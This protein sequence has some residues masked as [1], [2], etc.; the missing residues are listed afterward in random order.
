MCDRARRRAQHLRRDLRLGLGRDADAA[1]RAG[2]RFRRLGRRLHGYG[3]CTVALTQNATV[4]AEFL[5][6]RL[7][8]VSL[9]RA[10]RTAGA[11]CRSC[12]GAVCGVGPGFPPFPC[13]GSFEARDAGG[14][15][16]LRGA[17]LGLRGLGRSLHGHGH[18]IVSMTQHQVVTAEF[19]GPRLLAVN[20]REHRE[21][22][23]SVQI[24]PSA[25]SAAWGRASRPSPATD[26]SSRDAG[27]AHAASRL[28]T[29]SSVGWGGACT[30]TGT[31]IVPMTQ[32][33][34][35]TAEFL[36]PRLLAVNLMSTENGGGSVQIVPRARSVAWPGFRAPCNGSFKP[37]TP[38]EAHGLRRRPT[39]SSWAGAEPARAR[40]RASSR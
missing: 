16:G 25:R 14:A 18:R 31:C 30:G 34:V 26:R 13:N 15:H 6:P 5:G 37:G 11:A 17:R 32:H 7:L 22:R 19:L 4:T 20:H 29:R 3:L 33:Q 2:R 8:A 24:V 12:P 23:G 10:P 1:A 38:V 28:P 35:V 21:R 9:A 27:P 36:G 39:L 40:A